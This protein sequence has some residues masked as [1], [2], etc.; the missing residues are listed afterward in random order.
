MKSN[1]GVRTATIKLNNQTVSCVVD[2]GAS[3]NI[4]TKQTFAR[5]RK[6]AVLS[7]RSTAIFSYNSE[8]KLS[9]LGCFTTNTT[10]KE[11]NILAKFYV[12]DGNRSCSNLLSGAIS[13]KLRLIKFLN[14]VKVPAE[15]YRGFGKI[16]NI[17]VKLHIDDKVQPRLQAHRR[18]PYHVRK[19]LEK[20]L[21]H[22]KEQ[23]IIK[24][25]VGPT[26]WV[27]LN[28][29][30]PK[31][32]GGVRLCLDIREANKAIKRERHPMPTIEDI[33]NELNGS[34]VFSRID[35]H[36]AFHQLDLE[37]ESR[38]ITTFST[39]VGLKPFKRLMFGVNAAPELFQHALGEILQG[40]PGV[41][42]YIDDII[43]H[44][45]DKAA[46]DTS[47]SQ[48]LNRLQERGA[49]HHH[50]KRS[51]GRRKDLYVR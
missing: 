8:Q 22:L 9:V 18:V 23:D 38:F 27:S 2:T 5:F 49:I 16:K 33:I 32:T 11:N 40:I 13:E 7:A 37:E 12:V 35:L 24:D 42:H 17:K 15:L 14:Q 10:H 20:E 19:D 21:K 28:V 29:V 51:M 30:V 39:H 48:T 6:K 34:T 26:P 4:I 1:K 50:G 25:V 43:I 45:A 47:L 3:V 44:G 36:I 41:T 31:N 46:H